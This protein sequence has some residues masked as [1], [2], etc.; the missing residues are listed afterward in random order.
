MHLPDQEKTLAAL[1]ALDSLIVIDSLPTD[2]AHLASVAFADLPA[3]GKAGTTTSADRRISALTRGES[4]TGDQRDALEIIDA[5]GAALA[6]KLGKSGLSTGA[7][8]ATVMA[9]AS[10][11]VPGYAA[12]V[13]GKLA[14]GVTRSVDGSASGGRLQD[15]TAP[16]M[17][18]SNG[19]LLLLSSRSL[20]TSLEGASI[21]SEEADK[22]HREEF[23]EMNPADAAALRI[24]QNHPVVVSNGSSELT[25]PVALTDRVAP[26]SVYL[27]L[28]Y[29]G[30]AV[31]RLLRADDGGLQAVSIR[32]A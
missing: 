8:A 3:Y 30:G 12:A 28:Y 10:A 19:T 17:P 1:Q 2:T 21:H 15:V 32:P 6:E 24:Q 31:N 9:E 11:S 5:L 27:P 23:I 7:D 22:L 13:A 20:Y 4:A 25:L 18:S 26:G 14:S 29:D 16:A